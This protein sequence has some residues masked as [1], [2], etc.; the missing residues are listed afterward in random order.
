MNRFDK[1]NDRILTRIERVTD[2]WAKDFKGTTPFDKEPVSDKEL[3]ER[4]DGM[5]PE[6]WAELQMTHNPE[7]L[8]N[9]RNKMENLKIKGGYYA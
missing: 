8:E 1:I 7:D 2:K 6:Q 9:Y 5:T 4:Y 3:I